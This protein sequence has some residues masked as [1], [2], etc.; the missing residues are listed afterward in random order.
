LNQTPKQHQYIILGI[1]DDLEL[2]A[3]R[4]SITKLEGVDG[5]TRPKQ[6]SAEVKFVDFAG[7][8]CQTD[9]FEPDVFESLQPYRFGH[10]LVEALVAD[11]PVSLFNRTVVH[12]LITRRDLTTTGTTNLLVSM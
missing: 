8:I 1:T 9:W 2:V 5:D 3:G 7:A 4:M 10:F 12:N 6:I 11:L